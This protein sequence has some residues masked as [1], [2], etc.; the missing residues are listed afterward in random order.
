M[1][2]CMTQYGSLYDSLWLKN[3]R[4]AA[5]KYRQ[6]AEAAA[7][8]TAKDSAE[9]L[10]LVEEL[11]TLLINELQEQKAHEAKV[12][13]NQAAT[14]EAMLAAQAD[15]DASKVSA[16]YALSMMKEAED[17]A[18]NTKDVMKKVVPSWRTKAAKPIKE[19]NG[20][21]AAARETADAAE[22]AARQAQE[23]FAKRN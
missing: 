7:M 8:Q 11:K 1:A 19:V 14:R 12:K 23:K 4:I 2:R 21:A 3:I 6:T 5:K 18:S 16:E 20:A 13:A 10:R 22:N 15:F 17:A 9:A